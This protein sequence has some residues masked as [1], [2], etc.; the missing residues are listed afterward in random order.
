MEVE[1]ARRER[2][3]SPPLPD[4]DRS[5]VKSFQGYGKKKNKKAPAK[6]VPQLG[7]Q[8]KQSIP[9]LV[10]PNDQPPPQGDPN[11]DYL[12]AAY[13]QKIDVAQLQAFLAEANITD[14]QFRETEPMKEKDHDI[15]RTYKWGRSLVGKR[16]GQNL[17]RKCTT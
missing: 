17:V 15:F 4:Y 9:P 12:A 2:Q 1:K 14:G 8:A 7:M 5:L 10:I 11:L 16:T 3:R 13:G 6:D